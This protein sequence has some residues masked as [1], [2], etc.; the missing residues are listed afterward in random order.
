MASA[1]N[2]PTVT[3]QMA[4]VRVV[5]LTAAGAPVVGVTPV[6]THAGTAPCDYPEAFT[7]ANSDANGQSLA[8]MPWGTWDVTVPGY[9]LT[10]AVTPVFHPSTNEIYVEVRVQ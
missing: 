9:T 4:K 10:A 1:T 6:L 5:V 2:P 3:P 7:L 8:S